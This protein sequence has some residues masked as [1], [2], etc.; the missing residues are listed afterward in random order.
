M[1][2]GL[3]TLLPRTLYEIR[4]VLQTKMAML[5]SSSTGSIQAAIKKLL[6][7]G[8]IE[9]REERDGNVV[10]KIYILTEAGRDAFNQWVNMDFE[11]DK[12]RNPELLKLYF[13]GLSDPEHRAQRLQNHIAE[14][15]ESRDKMKK[16]FD[17]G[18]KLNVPAEFKELYTYQMMT[19]K[20]GLDYLNFQI[21][22]FKKMLEQGVDFNE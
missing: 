21:K 7:D 17:D 15:T 8:K 20:F 6:K 5:Y 1:I 11:S 10:K 19:A 18:H 13:M 16:I 3:L 9:Q 2:L 12:N 22:W 4:T 14:L